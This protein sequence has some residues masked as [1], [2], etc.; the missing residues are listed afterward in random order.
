MLLFHAD[1]DILAE[2]CDITTPAEMNRERMQEQGSFN[3]FAD[4]YIYGDK[5]NM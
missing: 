5:P 1:D 4:Q 3:P 2:D